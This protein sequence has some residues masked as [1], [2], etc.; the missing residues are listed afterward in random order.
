MLW[1][2]NMSS[3]NAKICHMSDCL[4]EEFLLLVIGVLSKTWQVRTYST[5]NG[6]NRKTY[7]ILSTENE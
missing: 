6:I 7:C 3:L 4:D 5:V 2:E 1:L